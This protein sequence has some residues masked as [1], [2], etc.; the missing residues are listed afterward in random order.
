[1]IRRTAILLGVLLGGPAF[2]G[3]TEDVLRAWATQK[4][5]WHGHI[6][7][8]SAQSPAPQ[9]VTLHSSWDA[10]P[11]GTGI[12]RIET[13][14]SAAGS[15]SSVTAMFA[16]PQTGDIVTPYFTNSVQRDYRFAVVSAEIT[17]ESHWT[18]VI[19]SPGGEEEYED[20]PAVLR[21]VR[22]RTGNSLTST[23]E[24]NFLDD[25]EDVFELRSYIEQ[26]LISGG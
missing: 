10:T 9:T 14:V 26:K 6:D 23:K 16:D 8:Y 2:G 3:A 18:T 7:I 21:Y 24:V 15:N 20:R 1:M 17:D 19:A 22:T 5:E 11:D 25:D 12:T 13:F 4:G